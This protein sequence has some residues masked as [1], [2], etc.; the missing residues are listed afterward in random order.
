MSVLSSLRRMRAHTTGTIAFILT[1]SVARSAMGMPAPPPTGAESGDPAPPP[2]GQAPPPVP[3][4]T[5][6][7]D[8]AAGE[9][10][11]PEDHSDEWGPTPSE[12]TSAP[13]GDPA[14]SPSPE[15][16]ASEEPA[17]KAPPA[18]AEDPEHR[19]KM[20]A[21]ERTAIAGYVIASAGAV[22]LV[23]LSFPAWIL[24]EVAEDRAAD[25]PLLTSEAELAR[26]EEERR[27]FARISALAGAGGLLLGGVLIAAG[28]GTRHRLRKHNTVSVVPVLG[29]T[30]GM[31]VRLRF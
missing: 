27:R 18:P 4:S 23:L 24:A 16:E 15:P 9:P 17:A 5:T 31:Q 14:Y 12:P 22:T 20:K 29:P 30:Q 11:P 19:A 7:P 21:M 8:D 3:S 13:T 2:G 26:R 28:L 1:L 6:P 25:D 10:R